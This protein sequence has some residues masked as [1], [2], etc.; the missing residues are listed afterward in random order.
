MNAESAELKTQRVKNR[1]TQRAQREI[2]AEG[3]EKSNAKC[4]EENARRGCG[5]KKSQ[6]A[7]GKENAE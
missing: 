2:H 3:V 1:I 7:L 4:A 5:V 6:R